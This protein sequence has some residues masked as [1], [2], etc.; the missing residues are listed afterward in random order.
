DFTARALDF[1]RGRGPTQIVDDGG[2]VTFLIHEGWRLEESGLMPDPKVAESP[3][4]AAALALLQ[5]IRKED[6]TYWHR[7]VRDL[8]GVS[9]ETTCGVNRLVALERDGRLLF[10]AINVNESVT[11]S[12]FDNTYGCRHSVVDGLFRATDVML[13]GKVAVVCGYG[14]VGKG[15]A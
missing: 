10:P 12:K 4:W 11:K 5:R 7:L 13:A 3:A 9:E 6:P 15:C 14:E 8:R 1:G 2:D